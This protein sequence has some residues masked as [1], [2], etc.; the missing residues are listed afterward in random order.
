MVSIA[1]DTQTHLPLL[2]GGLKQAAHALEGGRVAH[3]AKAGSHDG[4][5]DDFRDLGL[6]GERLHRDAVALAAAPCRAPRHGA[7]LFLHVAR[8]VHL[9]EAQACSV[10]TRRLESEA[11]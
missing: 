5:V 4:V 1:P 8:Q 9:V 11:R 7:A 3:Q 6:E 2:R 10:S